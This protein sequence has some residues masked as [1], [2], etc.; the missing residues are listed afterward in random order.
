[1]SQKTFLFKSKF[2]NPSLEILEK[3]K[4]RP[5]LISKIWNNYSTVYD[6][7]SAYA[8]ADFFIFVSY[9]SVSPGYIF[10][11]FV[12]ASFVAF[13]LMLAGRFYRGQ[14]FCFCYIFCCYLW[15]YCFYFVRW[16]CFGCFHWCCCVWW[17][18]VFSDFMVFPYSMCC[19][20]VTVDIVDY[21]V[22]VAAISYFYFSALYI[23]VGIGWLHFHCFVF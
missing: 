5:K 6:F 20:S 23:S 21:F 8:V 12:F 22:S 3:Y 15:I 4:N 2:R 19:W 7:M 9:F 10:Y 14:L 18:S 16:I 17:F 11:S 1:M 13:S